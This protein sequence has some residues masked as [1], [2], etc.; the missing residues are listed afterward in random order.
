MQGNHC[1]MFLFPASSFVDSF[2]DH[3]SSRQ[4]KAE[5]RSENE[6]SLLH[7]QPSQALLIL[8]FAPKKLE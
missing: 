7:V 3:V 8:T 4:E 6:A 1:S 5:C 2:Q